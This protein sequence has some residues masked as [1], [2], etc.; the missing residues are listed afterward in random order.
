ME[1]TEHLRQAQRLKKGGS[2]GIG[3]LLISELVID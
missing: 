3:A 2:K 1:K